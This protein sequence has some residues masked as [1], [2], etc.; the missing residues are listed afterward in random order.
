MKHLM[1]WLSLFASLVWSERFFDVNIK[2]NQKCVPHIW[3]RERKQKKTSKANIQF[4]SP[5]M[6]SSSLQQS[7]PSEYFFSGFFLN[8]NFF[9]IFISL[10][11]FLFIS[12]IDILSNLQL[13]SL[14][15]F[16]FVFR[17]KEK[18]K[19]HFFVSNQ[20]ISV[21]DV[22]AMDQARFD[23]AV[24]LVWIGSWVGAKICCVSRSWWWWCSK[25][26]RWCLFRMHSCSFVTFKKSKQRHIRNAAKSMRALKKEDV[27]HARFIQKPYNIYTHARIPS[28]RG[29]NNIHIDRIKCEKG[30]GLNK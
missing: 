26:W 25:R 1:R 30:S 12:P 9:S 17:S 14:H 16:F 23:T 7:S 3:V 15:L 21:S 24:W 29:K 10:R 28:R 8:L 19:M 13:D 5:L 27:S 6:F 2:A 18:R 22:Y 11:E 4:V 20:Y